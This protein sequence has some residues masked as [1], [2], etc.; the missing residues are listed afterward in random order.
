MKLLCNLVLIAAVL[1]VPLAVSADD[2]APAPWR[3]APNSVFAK[4]DLLAGPVPGPPVSFGYG[5]GY[6]LDPTPPFV[7]G[8]ITTPTG[9]L[10]YDI[11]LPNVIDPL[12]LKLMRIQYSWFGGTS[13]GGHADTLSIL[14]IPGGVVTHVGGSPPIVLDP[15]A[16]I[17]HRYDDFEIRPN[18]DSERIQVRFTFADPRWVIID[19]ISIPEPSSVALLAVCGGFALMRRSQ[20]R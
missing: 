12:P 10:I 20:R 11:T 9:E 6:P 17:L 4:F 16:G 3:G 1:L 7:G 8:P 2:V 5:G 18:P 14:P 15:L 13:L 19:T